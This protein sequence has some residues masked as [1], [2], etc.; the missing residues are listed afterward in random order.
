MYNKKKSS[1]NVQ[2]AIKLDFF[3][4]YHQNEVKFEYSNR[5]KT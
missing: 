1:L 5:Y 4:L 3:K 2:I